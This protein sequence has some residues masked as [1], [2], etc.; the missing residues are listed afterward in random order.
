M[1]RGFLL[2]LFTY[3][4]AL[5][6][7][8]TVGSRLPQVLSLLL[9]GPATVSKARMSLRSWNGSEKSLGET[10]IKTSLAPFH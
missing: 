6:L 9:G 10:T 2:E 5:D 1:D 7:S 4:K 3:H 8:L